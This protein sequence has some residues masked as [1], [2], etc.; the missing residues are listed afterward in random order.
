LDRNHP[1][2]YQ[3]RGIALIDQGRIEEGVQNL[4]HSIQQHGAN[5]DTLLIQASALASL[6]RYEEAIA[7]CDSIL[8][9]EP[10]HLQAIINKGAYFRALGRVDDA[11]ACLD[12]ALMIDTNNIQAMVEKG[13]TLSAA[14]RDDEALR[15]YDAA[16]SVDPNTQSAYLNK[17]ILMGK[18]GRHVEAID[19]YDNAISLDPHNFLSLY[20]R[21][22]EL[23]HIEKF[24]D[25]I[26]AFSI[27]CSMEPGFTP[28]GYRHIV[29]VP[30]RTLKIRCTD[31]PSKQEDLLKEVQYQSKVESVNVARYISH[32]VKQEENIMW[33]L[34]VT[35]TVSSTLEDIIL[36]GTLTID[37]I[38]HVMVGILKGLQ[39]IH[40]SGLV[41]CNIKPSRIGVSVP[42]NSSEDIKI[43]DFG[44]CVPIG[45]MPHSV[46]KEWACPEFVTDKAQRK[47]D[48]FSAGLVLQNC[49]ESAVREAPETEGEN[50]LSLV[51]ATACDADPLQRFEN[52]QSMLSEFQ[53]VW[54]WS[55][56]RKYKPVT[57]TTYQ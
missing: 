32:S 20:N 3:S 44:A 5:I 15:C 51:V 2:V 57:V 14:G 6:G 48:L 38:Y 55:K 18:L 49:L 52:A 53:H 11:L 25:A 31:D 39:H 22:I 45:E 27:A 23:A 33:L 35:E 1:S 12:A 29:H 36:N 56:S 16:L 40:E 28:E 19:N 26:E 10:E 34:I 30:G 47:T 54:E 41:H 9:A 43:L 17:G 46:T 50:G 24:D 21:A 8:G 4:E 7:A 13:V 42:I 37:M